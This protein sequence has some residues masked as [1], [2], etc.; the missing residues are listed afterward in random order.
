M[1]A[2]I[3]HGN[4]QTRNSGIEYRVLELKEDN[5]GILR[6]VL[7]QYGVAPDDAKPE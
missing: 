3:K 2:L 5:S 1:D 7:A 6:A 4:F